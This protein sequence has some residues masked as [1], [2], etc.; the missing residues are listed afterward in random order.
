LRFRKAYA[1]AGVVP[2]ITNPFYPVFGRGIQDVAEQQGYD[3]ILY[4]TDG[5]PEKEQKCLYALQRGRID[6]V[7]GVFFHLTARELRQL[8]ERGIFVVRL[9]SQT[10][11][12]GPL[13]LDN[14]YVD[15]G[16]AARA[17]VSYLISKGHQRIAMITGQLGP[18]E[19][20]VLGYQQALRE[21][22]KR[23]EEHLIE[24]DDFT[25]KGG[26]SAMWAL[27]QQAQSVSAVF[28]ANDLMAISA[29][30]AIR[31]AGLRVPDDIAVVGFD[32]IPAAVL[33]SPALTT[34]TQFPAKL[35]QRAAEMLF[36]RLQG[37]AQEGGRCEEMPYR[38]VVRESA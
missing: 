31:E 14:L 34:I 26:Y 30:T 10:K 33:V 25:E 28:A 22:E 27:L 6:G 1:I 11:A 37:S 18:R 29:M 35:G 5:A 23:L 2:D 38:L 7:I 21:H 24:V 20:R 4:N 17:A 8:L 13:P 32:D 9:E 3:F 36:E 12:T 16:A 15:N 19:M